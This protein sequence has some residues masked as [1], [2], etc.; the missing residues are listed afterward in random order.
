[1]GT[2]SANGEGRPL[3]SA[4][5]QAMPGPTQDLA[6]GKITVGGRVER[7]DILAGYVFTPQHFAGAVNGDASIGAVKIGAGWAASNLV[8]GVAAGIGKFGDADDTV[9][10]G[11]NAG[12]TAT[13]ASI[14]IGGQVVGTPELGSD[15]F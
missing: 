13:I 1:V 10:S 11:G 14:V 3:I 9:I 7:A 6:I 4:G 8:A 2:V 5:G 12:L 15:H